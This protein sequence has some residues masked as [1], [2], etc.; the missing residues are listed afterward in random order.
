MVCEVLV[1]AD[2]V[3]YGT[4]VNNLWGQLD[5]V[6]VGGITKYDIRRRGQI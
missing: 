4:G 3:I 1:G 6:C 5:G 2:H